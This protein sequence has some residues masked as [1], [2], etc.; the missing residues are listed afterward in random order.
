MT[1]S[2][3][4]KGVNPKT[5]S[6]SRSGVWNVSEIA[7]IKREQK[8]VAT[9]ADVAVVDDYWADENIDPFRPQVLAHFT[10]NDNYIHVMDDLSGNEHD[11]YLASFN[12]EQPVCIMNDG[13]KH[14]FS[15]YFHD[16]FYSISDTA[17]SP[18]VR[19]DSN[20][21]TIEFHA[22]LLRNHGA[23][24]FLMGKG[25]TAGRAQGAGWGIFANATYNIGFHDA[26]SN[27]IIVSSEALNRD[28]WYHIAIV[29]EGT[30]TNQTKIYIDGNVKATGTSTGNFNDASTMYIGRD[31]VST[32]TTY[33]GGRMCDLRIRANAEYTANFTPPTAP[34]DT[35]NSLLSISATEPFHP[36]HPT[37]QKEGLVFTMGSSNMRRNCISPFMDKTTNPYLG[38]GKNSLHVSSGNPVR[39]VDYT[40]NTT[41]LLNFQT[42]PFTVE[43]WVKTADYGINFG[44]CGKGTGNFGAGTG[45]SAY[46]DTEGDPAWSDASAT[47]AGSTHRIYYGGW[48]HVAYVRENTGTNGFKIYLNGKLAHTG[49][50]STNYSDGESLRIMSTRNGQYA[51]NHTFLSCLKISKTARYTEEFNV[52]STTFMDS[53]LTTDANTSILTCTSDA[54]RLV[55]PFGGWVN[56]G[57]GSL[58]FVPRSNH[59]YQGHA[60]PNAPADDPETGLGGHSIRF[61]GGQNKVLCMT[62]PT[63]ADDFYFSTGDFSIEFWWNSNQ[64]RAETTE[65]HVFF[66]MR[67]AWADSGL[68]LCATTA[69]GLELQGNNSIILSVDDPAW[70]YSGKW[71]HICVQRV[72]GAAAL[73]INGQKKA[74]SIFTASVSSPLNRITIGTGS[75]I[76]LR[77]DKGIYGYVSNFRVV[78]GKGA[79]GYYTSEG[80]SNPSSFIVPVKPLEATPETV[81]LTGYGPMMA[82]YSGRDNRVGS[83][84]LQANV[85]NMTSAWSS[86][87]TTFSP[88]SPQEEFRSNSVITIDMLNTVSGFYSRAPE[89]S[90]YGDR[91]AEIGF[92][93]RMSKPWTIE[94]WVQGHNVNPGAPSGQEILRTAFTTNHTGFQIYSHINGA[95]A[96][97]RED[98]F[99]RM[100]QGTQGT[101]ILGSTGNT[102]NYKPHGSNHI[103]VQYDPTKTNKM[104]IF[105]N[106]KRVASNT[107]AMPALTSTFLLTQNFDTISQGAGSMRVSDTARYDNDASFYTMPTKMWVYDQNTF[108]IARHGMPFFDSTMRNPWSTYGATVDKTH[109]KF[110]NAS[111]FFPNDAQNTTHVARAG[112]SSSTWEIW[113]K[114]A[115]YE[116]F[117]VECWA[118]WWDVAS[119]GKAFGTN[120]E[121]SC[122]YHYANGFWVGVDPNGFW[123]FLIKN[124]NSTLYN[125]YKSDV[126]VATRSS[127][128][129]DFIVAMRRGRNIIFYVNGVQKQIVAWNGQGAYGSSILNGYSHLTDY[130]QTSYTYWAFGADNSSL[131]A[132]KWCGHMEDFRYTHAARYETRVLNGVATMCHIGTDIPALPTGPFPTR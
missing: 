34:L 27:I 70:N 57:W 82:D 132:T 48:Y 120:T 53:M 39:I 101:F 62:N 108:A 123:Q 113:P 109:T 61:L 112:L 103:A 78:K 96:A 69:N 25:N 28:Q 102:G 128:N 116:D 117:T 50:V 49:T 79:Y 84:G 71:S 6:S 26:T 38:K 89:S 10:S 33:F 8:A 92:I 21:F 2:R 11:G 86:Y 20:A 51:A 119:G 131:Q 31:R 29:R 55:A 105:C 23:E 4:H 35:S 1:I 52:N 9:F 67:T 42:G 19:L 107:S 72:N 97:S 41:N 104:A 77:Y 44:I 63:T 90:Y 68:C 73:Y 124:A 32:S 110:S 22:M 43:A 37:W 118:S 13:P 93:N 65:H 75:Y 87:I 5:T 74:E 83:G 40:A 111:M 106:G 3:R 54:D 60:Y 88:F 81:L 58:T 14:F 126:Q 114:D 80:N 47:L 45:W 127:G 129:F 56:D 115:R 95:A 98:V 76:G 122:L 36:N 130:V 125:T 99:F 94:L 59:G 17:G 46:I 91:W 121:G 12:H 30:G 24:H 18:N 64:T 100:W 7:S 85:E 15:T 16:G 66:D